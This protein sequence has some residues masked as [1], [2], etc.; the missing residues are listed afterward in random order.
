MHV[1]DIALN[2]AFP[3]I[4]TVGYLQFVLAVT[5]VT[6]ERSFSDMRQVKTRLR[7]RLE[8]NTVDQ[9]MYVCIEG[10]PTLSDNKLDTI[11]THL[12]N[13]KPRRLNA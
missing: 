6:V 10:P 13:M 2:P 7:S 1:A 3:N 9:A 5:I 8:E 12:K 11:V 4:A